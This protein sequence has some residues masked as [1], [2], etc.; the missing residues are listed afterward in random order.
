MN[1][2]KKKLIESGMKLFAQKGFH[3]TSI[4]EIA[5]N[6]E[7]SKGAF[8]LHFSSKEDFILNIYE[9]YY[10]DLKSRIE[11]ARHEG[12]T[13]RETM[14]KQIQV[15]MQTIGEF[16]D[17]IIMVIR[18][19][20]SLNQEMDDFLYEMKE[21]SFKWTSEHLRSMYGKDIEPYIVD[22]V[23]IV[24]GLVS[25]SVRWVVASG[26]SINLE[27][28]ARFIL[29]RIDDAIQGMLK[30]GGEP[31][32]APE[33]FLA[34]Y[35]NDVYPKKNQDIVEELLYDMRHELEKLEMNGDHKQDLQDTIDLLLQE[36]QLEEPKKIL[37]QGMLTHF[38]RVPELRENSERIA[39][40][41]NTQ[42]F[43]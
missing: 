13:P 29:R 15:L 23:L 5:D 17:F 3:S 43:Q 35:A 32:I 33:A 16:R 6:S 14:E 12:D 7:V 24:Q 21:T 38:Q 40:Q 34:T 36:I 2:K 42:L 31:R 9:Y 39:R 20:I 10:V 22:G 1:E 37:F 28:L 4:Q 26:V 19:N 25:E 41:L 8:Y 11:A 30:E 18:D 27:S